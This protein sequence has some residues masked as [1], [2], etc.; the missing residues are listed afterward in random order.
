MRLQNISTYILELVDCNNYVVHT[1]LLTTNFPVRSFQNV[2][3][4]RGDHKVLIIVACKSSSKSK[5]TKFIVK[6][7]SFATKFIT[8]I[9][10][11]PVSCTCRTCQISSFCNLPVIC[12]HSKQLIPLDC[13]QNSIGSNSGSEANITQGPL[14]IWTEHSNC[15]IHSRGDSKTFK[16]LY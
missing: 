4:I 15:Q 14:Y 1:H 12:C 11:N 13:I 9:N 8:C 6:Y 10:F 3:Y 7:S 16:K 2:R 5:S